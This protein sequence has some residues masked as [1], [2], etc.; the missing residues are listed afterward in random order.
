H[1]VP[2][3]LL[4][5]GDPAFSVTG[6]IIAT[7]PAGVNDSGR[8][9]TSGS[10]HQR[11]C[12]CFVRGEEGFDREFRERDVDRGAEHGRGAEEGQFAFPGPETEGDHHATV[13]RGGNPGLL[14]A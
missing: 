5:P 2:L 8:W 14:L 13:V 3:R 7:S 10:A 9:R 12:G 1:T 11:G 4:A 6:I